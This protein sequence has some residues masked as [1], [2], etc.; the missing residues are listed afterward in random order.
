MMNRLVAIY[1]SI[2]GIFSFL[3]AGS[4][5]I[6]YTIGPGALWNIGFFACLLGFS[7]GIVTAMLRFIIWPYVFYV[8][9]GTDQS[10][11]HWLFYLWY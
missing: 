3:T 1:L 9:L 10:L 2:G 8:T 4:T 5:V 7:I 11:Q 6:F